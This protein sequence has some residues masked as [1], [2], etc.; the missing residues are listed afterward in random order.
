[1]IQFPLGEHEDAVFCISSMCVK[2]ARVTIFT[3]RVLLRTP[4]ILGQSMDPSFGTPCFLCMCDAA[5]QCSRKCTRAVPPVPPVAP[6][7]PLHGLPSI[8][9]LIHPRPSVAA[10]GIIVR[11]LLCVFTI[12]QDLCK[13]YCCDFFT[14]FYLNRILQ[15][16]L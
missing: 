2:S 8:Y 14:F 10:R 1:M 13:I 7:C 5:A 9:P 12:K 16:R 3:S 4:Y 11:V 15:C 6:S